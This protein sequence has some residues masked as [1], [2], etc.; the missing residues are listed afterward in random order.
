MKNMTLYPM[1]EISELAWPKQP[2]ALSLDTPAEVFFTDF[3]TVQPRIIEATTSALDAKKVMMKTHIRLLFVVNDAD[4]FVG[5][6]TA[7]D[8]IERKIVQQ[9]SLGFRRED[10]EVT[11]L[12][13]PKRQLFALDIAAVQRA[14]IND[15][16]RVLKDSHQQHCLV[17]D[18][19]EPKIRGIFSTTDISRKLNLHIDTENRS[20]FYKVFEVIA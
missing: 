7:D 18:S 19:E 3:E 2:K 17:I 12:M 10:I 1:A 11:D 13:T 20:D 4:H 8:L 15:V 14:T 9:V 5:V 16:I 6:I